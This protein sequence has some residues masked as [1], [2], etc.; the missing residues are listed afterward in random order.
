[1]GKGTKPFLWCLL[2]A[3]KSLNENSLR[4][5]NKMISDECVNEYYSGYGSAI[6]FQDK[7]DAEYFAMKAV[8][9]K[10]EQAQNTQPLKWESSY[11]YNYGLQVQNSSGPIINSSVV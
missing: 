6:L 2:G 11:L 10:S 7:S 8:F 1:M 5:L 9:L 3:K 4:A